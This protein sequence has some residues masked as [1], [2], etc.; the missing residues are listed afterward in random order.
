[1]DD[2]TRNGAHGAQAV[3]PRWQ[4]CADF[5]QKDH[6]KASFGIIG[7]SLEQDS[8]AYFKWIKDLHQRGIIEFWNHGYVNQADQ[9]KGPSMEA[10][11][12]ALEKTQR[13]AREKL[14]FPLRAFGVHWS[15]TD[16]ATAQALAAIPEI[17]IWFQGASAASGKTLLERTVDLEHPTFVPNPEHV[18]AGYEKYGSHPYLVLQGHPNKWDDARFDAFVKAVHYLEEKGCAFQRVSEYVDGG[19]K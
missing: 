8:P 13:L 2:L 16:D 19:G 7:E 15:A 1:L 11:K 17:R 12:A 6:L 18:R 4:R 5:I 3:S 14:G 10:Q 9:F